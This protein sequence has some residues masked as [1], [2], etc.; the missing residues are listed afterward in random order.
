MSKTKHANGVDSIMAGFP[1]QPDKIVGEPTYK[2]IREL[3]DRLEENA[4]SIECGLGGGANGYLGVL[5]SAAEYATILGTAPF[6]APANPGH[7]A[8]PVAGA[9]AAIANQSRVYEEAYRQYQE[10]ANVVKALR[11]QLVAAVDDAYIIALKHD[12]SMYNAVPLDQML[13]HLYSEYGEISHEDFKHN[14]SKFNE[15]WDRAEPIELIVS[16]WNKCIKLAAAAGKPYTNEQIMEKTYTIVYDCG[17][18]Y[19]ELK[20]WKKKTPAQKTYQLFQS[21]VKAAQKEYRLQQR[22]SKRSG[23]GLATQELVAA[24]EH[25]AYFM[26]QA[27]AKE[28]TANALSQEK[29]QN[30]VA[31]EQ[32]LLRELADIRTLLIQQGTCVP[33]N[34]QQLNIPAPTGNPG[35]P[36]RKRRKDTGGYCWTHGYFVTATHT[37]ATCAT[38]TSAMCA[39]KRLSHIDTATRENNMG[40]SQYG[41][42]RP[43]QA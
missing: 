4:T 5:L 19:E 32:R 23:Y 43:A 13:A 29:E 38:H 15:P 3:Q 40:G 6:I 30:A 16:R 22:T 36:A 39:T 41:K 11:K 28:T 9:A 37:S 14:E 21:H 10:Y 24:T 7:T 31:K 26:A 35:A 17:L 25:F 33:V 18:Y 8:P 20:D 42:P 27:E 34:N 1:S 12:R 2:T